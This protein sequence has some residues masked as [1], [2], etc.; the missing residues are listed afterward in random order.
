MQRLVALKISRDRGTE[1]MTLAQLDHPHIVRV[2][3]Q[4]RIPDRNL[5]LLYMQFAAGG[6]LH[7]VIARAKSSD[8]RTGDLVG[9]SIAAALSTTGVISPNDV[10]LRPELAGR[11]WSE[12]T[13]R[14]GMELATALS[15]AHSQGILHRDVKPANVLLDAGGS[16][17]LADF[18]ISFSESLNACGAAAYFGGSLAYMS[19]EQLEACH[20]GHA[21]RAE[22]LDGRSDVF[23]LGVLLWELMFGT[24]PFDDNAV[25]GGWSDAIEGMMSVRR[26]GPGDPPQ[27]PSDDTGRE[28]LQILRKCLAPDPDDRFTTAQELAG[29]LGLCLQPRVATLLRKHDS[30]VP[31][32][33]VRHPLIA[34]VLATMV[35]NVLSARF[36][37]V[38]NLR[39]I[40]GQMDEQARN[41]FDLLERT[42]DLT[43]FPTGLTGTLVFASPVLFALRRR[44]N[45][46]PEH[47]TIARQRSLFLGTF[48]A[49]IGIALW[50]IAGLAYPIGLHSILGHF[51]AREYVHFFG[52]MLICGMIAAAYPFFILLWLAVRGYF[53]ALLRGQS[54]TPED[55]SA[56]TSVN[57]QTRWLLF[58]AGSVPAVGTLMLLATSDLDA[59]HN[60]LALTVLSAVG[61]IGFAVAFAL[62]RILQDDIAALLEAARLC[63]HDEG[64]AVNFAHPPAGPP[65]GTSATFPKSV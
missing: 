65:N 8:S 5:R 19:P 28:L 21:R 56:L 7:S 33:A 29:N 4:H 26:A 14:L 23:S 22:E 63:G 38:Y 47:R 57:G 62:Y 27:P 39:A 60:R 25:S 45:V 64:S 43:A 40:I 17:K 9:E 35:P 54:L 55:T 16:A 46:T 37:Y 58:V 13:C 18:N 53:P 50:L 49:G 36:N 15:Y 11:P 32:M 41:T 10:P 2:H 24:R 12:V 3:D 48:A 61:A 42:I 31:G 6:T 59:T 1:A 20:P 51:P 44:R 52:S 30:G 34:L